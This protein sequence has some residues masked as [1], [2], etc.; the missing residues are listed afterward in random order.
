MPPL[1]KKRKT[2]SSCSSS[3]DGGLYPCEECDKVFNK[4]SSLA[5][6]KYEHSGEYSWSLWITGW[7]CCGQPLQPFK[8]NRLRTVER[9]RERER[10]RELMCAEA[11]TKTSYSITGHLIITDVA[12]ARTFL[13][14]RSA[15]KQTVLCYP[16]LALLHSQIWCQHQI[17]SWIAWCHR[18][19]LTRMCCY[20]LSAVRDCHHMASSMNT[21]AIFCAVRP[22]IGC[23]LVTVTKDLHMDFISTNHILTWPNGLATLLWFCNNGSS[24]EI[25]GRQAHVS[26]ST[27]G[28]KV[29]L[30]DSD[31]CSVCTVYYMLSLA[32]GLHYLC[33]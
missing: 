17:V 29:R 33:F 10:E 4:Q 5:R 13:T 1:H 16:S 3:D 32:H 25:N 8:T 26:L 2:L 12:E 19:Q 28:L 30:T 20:W 21:G 9:E 22:A 23:L 7:M 14:L 11:Q 18:W 24:H 15:I 27:N 31:G 6:H